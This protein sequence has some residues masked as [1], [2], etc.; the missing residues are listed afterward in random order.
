V[1]ATGLPPG[2]R[3][4]ADEVPGFG[5]C[6]RWIF[7]RNPMEAIMYKA[8]SAA[9]TQR[10]LARHASEFRSSG[11]M[12]ASLGADYKPG[13]KLIREWQGKVHEV[14]I[15]DDGYIWSGKRYRSLSEIARGITGKRWSGPRFF[16]TET[17]RRTPTAAGTG[18]N[19]SKSNSVAT[20]S[21]NTDSMH[22]AGLGGHRSAKAQRGS[23]HG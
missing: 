18:S 22:P 2:P 11:S 9:K 17:P 13:T 7:R 14:V 21:L 23:D 5:R 1:A 12:S 20:A 6:K 16:G 19:L 15:L 10:S 8:E 3:C 4:T